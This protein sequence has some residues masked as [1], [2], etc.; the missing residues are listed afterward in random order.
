M[1]S[2][3]SLPDVLDHVATRTYN[4]S[5]SANWYRPVLTVVIPNM[6]YTSTLAP[7][8]RIVPS[9][10]DSYNHPSPTPDPLVSGARGGMNWQFESVLVL[11]PAVFLFVI[12]L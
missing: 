9:A 7:T 3:D 11:W 5:D 1:H 12:V 8:T 2:N 6:T 4:E 10:Y